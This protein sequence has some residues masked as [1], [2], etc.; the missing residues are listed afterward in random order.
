MPHAAS[1]TC[2][3]CT[4][5]IS[6][7]GPVRL[8]TPYR[9]KRKTPSDEERDEEDASDRSQSTSTKSQK[10]IKVMNESGIIET[11]VL[12]TSSAMSTSASAA[13]SSTPSGSSSMDEDMGSAQMKKRVLVAPRVRS[14]GQVSGPA[15]FDRLDDMVSTV[16]RAALHL[17]NVVEEGKQKFIQEYESLKQELKEEKEKV[18]RLENQLSLYNH[19]GTGAHEPEGPRRLATKRGEGR[20]G[21]ALAGSPLAS[22][23]VCCS[24]APAVFSSG[25]KWLFAHGVG[26]SRGVRG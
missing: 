15:I 20:G 19:V 7:Q 13:S 6:M 11:V 22:E 23:R 14:I 1:C 2:S 26:V 9:R 10:L 5:D 25:V 17:K 12:P 21:G 16:L 8:F 3:A 18:M 24:D 4:D